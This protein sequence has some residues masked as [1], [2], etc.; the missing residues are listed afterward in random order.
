MRAAY[1]QALPCPAP[2]HFARSRN[3]FRQRI[4]I[5]D[6]TVVYAG[7]SPSAALV[8]HALAHHPDAQRLVGIPDHRHDRRLQRPQAGNPG[9]GR[10]SRRYRLQLK[11]D[12]EAVLVP[13]VPP[14]LRD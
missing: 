13:A 1:H 14:P 2:G 4:T 8:V 5:T 11:P 6:M 3:P 12:G 7:S 10:R 9:S